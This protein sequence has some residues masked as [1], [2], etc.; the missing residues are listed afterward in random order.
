MN[1]LSYIATLHADLLIKFWFPRRLRILAKVL[2]SIQ[3]PCLNAGKKLD[4][5]MQQ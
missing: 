2:Y 5:V 1:A 3:Q 4:I